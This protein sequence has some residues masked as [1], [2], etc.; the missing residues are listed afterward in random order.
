VSQNFMKFSRGKL[1][2]TI[3]FLFLLVLLCAF[4]KYPEIL[5]KRP[6][7]IHHW[8]QADCASLT[9]NYY[10]HGMHF[11][12]PEVL[13]YTSDG[14]KS[15]YVCPSEIPLEYYF[16][17]TLYKIFGFHDFIYRIFNT[18]IFL[19]GLFY[20][21][22]IFKLITKDSFWSIG[23]SL[24]MFT[25]PV[26][27]Y[28]G[29]NFLTNSSAFALVLVA[30]FFFFRFYYEEKDRD[31][32]I[33]M[34]LFF[35]AASCKISALLS[36][37]AILGVYL[38]DIF[39][40]SSTKKG[41]TVFFKK[42][43]YGWAFLLIFALMGIWVAFAKHYNSVHQAQGY[44]STQIMPL[45]QMDKKSFNLVL[46]HVK[47]LWLSQYFSIYALFFLLGCLIFV[48][49]YIKRTD[50]FLG[51]IL[52]F[53]FIGFVSYIILWFQTFKDHDYYTIDLYIFLIFVLF[54]FANSLENRYPKVFRSK[55][56]KL[57]F[58]L[59]L[60]YNVWYASHEMHTRYEGWMN[61][62]PEYKDVYT[63][64]P[65]L[66]SIGIK[67]EDKVVCLPDNSHFTLYLM[68]QPGWTG[69]YGYNSDSAGIAASVKLGAKY[70]ILV[71]TN[72]TSK[73]YLQSYM[74]DKAGEYKTIRIFRLDRPENKRFALKRPEFQTKQEVCCDAETLTSDKKSFMDRKKT[75][76]FQG[77][78]CQSHEKHHSGRASIELTRNRA[79]GMTCWFPKSVK[80]EKFDITVWRSSE[81][82]N[83]SVVASAKNKDEFYI[84]DYD[85][86]K[87]VNKWELLRLAFI[88]PVQPKD[89]LLAVYLWDDGD[90]PVYF[91]DLRVKRNM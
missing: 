62:Y 30:W 40:V 22:K 4:Y 17:A 11:F 61:E 55:W 65:Y 48:L 77:G 74:N 20:L 3:I 21:F 31:F 89:S 91:D 59:F 54:T 73:E 24:F 36:V 88:L 70:L 42:L 10:Q 83:G 25:S 23:L 37:F 46:D 32:Y 66:R 26:L 64:T 8:R 67:P 60:I 15:G 52:S 50:K 1:Q 87:K 44:F 29:N 28:Y 53:L 6:Q 13:N 71:G 43:N 9:L 33:S 49:T 79:F 14:R 78:I 12:R 35:L 72:I 41:S 16:V 69:C 56:A 80:G 63:V 90:S 86:V 84:R 75:F 85:V 5:F 18:I 68:N 39:H 57:V 45:W 47:N 34:I 27:V 82:G 76:C 81:K 19:L 51:Y 38:L 58:S 7:S 2:D